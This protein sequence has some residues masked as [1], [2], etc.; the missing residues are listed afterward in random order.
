M[1]E[2]IIFKV[3]RD[4]NA[5]DHIVDGITF[6]TKQ[7]FTYLVHHVDLSEKAKV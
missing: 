3:I 2:E 6:Y 1:K 5:K 7:L 4:R